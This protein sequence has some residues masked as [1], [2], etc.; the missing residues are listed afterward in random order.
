MRAAA[1]AGD[2]ARLGDLAHT[3]KGTLGVFGAEP[4]IAAARQLEKATRAGRSADVA[5]ELAG[6][7]GEFNRVVE[8]LQS[9][10]P[11]SV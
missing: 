6:F 1:A 11:P 2:H 5:R 10:R 9:H 8:A 4:A 3:L 7:L